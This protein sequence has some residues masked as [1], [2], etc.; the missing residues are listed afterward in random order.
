[1]F[2]FPAGVAAP[3][4]VGLSILFFLVLL[5]GWWLAFRDRPGGYTWA[6]MTTLI[7][8]SLITFRSATTNQ[9]I[10]YLP[11][12][13]FF[14]RLGLFPPFKAGRWV[15]VTVSLIEIGSIVLMWGV[16]TVTLE[17]NWEHVMMHGL[18]PALMLLLYAV[19]WRALWQTAQEE[20]P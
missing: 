12:F 20:Y 14:R 1:H 4:T 7:V 10:L 6:M 9:M 17:G 8:G 13:F 18:L 16:F 11:L 3:L 19:D 2:F 15:R 5:P